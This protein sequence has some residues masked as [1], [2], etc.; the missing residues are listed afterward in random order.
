V[1]F[2]YP[3]T[4]QPFIYPEFFE[5]VIPS[6]PRR[7]FRG[8]ARKRKL[9]Q[10][11]L[12][13]PSDEELC[14]RYRQQSKEV[15]DELA[16]GAAAIA[17]RPLNPLGTLS[18]Y[19]SNAKKFQCFRTIYSYEREGGLDLFM[20]LLNWQERLAEWVKFIY[21]LGNRGITTNWLNQVLSATKYFLRTHDPDYRL[22]FCGEANREIVEA[23]RRVNEPI[24]DFMRAL[25][26]KKD[27]RS[28]LP[29]WVGLMVR[30][31]DMTWMR[32]GYTRLEWAP[33]PRRVHLPPPPMCHRWAEVQRHRLPTDRA[34][35]PG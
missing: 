29:A 4:G 7:D 10:V 8:E 22:D 15:M 27:E 2:V 31:F 1:A 25:G 14:H 13:P 35:P 26:V 6:P 16:A 30:S 19:K 21:Y 23:K 28:R 3:G 32:G 20:S 9:A 5:N 17:L 11:S 34:S 24:R 12:A 18:T 33:S